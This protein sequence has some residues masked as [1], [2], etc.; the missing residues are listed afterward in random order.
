MNMNFSAVPALAGAGRSQAA[1]ISAVVATLL[2]CTAAF[3]GAA[4]AAPSDP[5][6]VYTG[7]TSMNPAETYANVG[8]AAGR[9]ISSTSVLPGS[10]AGNAC[11]LLSLNQ[12]TF[13]GSQVATLGSYLAGGGRV[14]MIGE[15]DNYV[16]NAAFR[17]LATALGSSMQILNN[18]LDPGFRDTFNIDTDPLTR[19]VTS[20]I[21]AA[22]ASVTFSGPARSLVRTSDGGATMMAAE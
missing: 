15:N 9:P 20:I 1:R 22:T 13:S 19:D 8:T 2:A 21:Y 18:A 10:L 6:L 12:A 16:N 11:V 7:N 3:A 14:V 5:I 17:G 4:V